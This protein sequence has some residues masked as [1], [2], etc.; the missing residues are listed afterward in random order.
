MHRQGLYLHFQAISLSSD[1]VSHEILERSGR[2]LDRNKGLVDQHNIELKIGVK[3][4][5]TL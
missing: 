2:D 3:G 5:D 1:V 4:S